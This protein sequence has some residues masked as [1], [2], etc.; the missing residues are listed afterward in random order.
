[1]SEPISFEAYLDSL[2][3]LTA[4]VDPTASTPEAEDIRHATESLSEIKPIN[5]STLTR[6][7][8]AH[9]T[10]TLVLGLSAG[11]SQEKL[12]NELRHEFGTSGWTKLAQ[13][14]PGEL[15]SWL[16]VEFDLI[17]MLKTQLKRK[18]G[19]ADVLIARAERRVTATR[20]GISGRRVEDEIEAIAKD[21]GLPYVTRARFTGRHGR[22][23]PGDL[24][25]PNATSAD[26]AVAAKGFDSTGSKLT[27][28]VREIE[29]MADVRLPTQFVMAVIDGIGWKSRQSDLRRIHLLW[30]NKQIDGLYTLSSTSFATTFRWRPV[31]AT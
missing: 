15:I 29:E 17:R 7:V 10:W 28:A 11:L 25:I 31:C 9:P 24:L 18:Y 23:A 19:F 22:S 16:D 2:G 27:D 21:L 26:I 13:A 4:R 5:A 14:K 1:M 3:R 8:Q 6:W 30:T 12:K 20:A